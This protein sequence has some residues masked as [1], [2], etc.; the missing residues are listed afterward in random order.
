MT[1]QAA[2]R[3]TLAVL[4]KFYAHRDGSPHPLNE[5]QLVVYLDG[6]AAYPPE[7]LEAAARAWM[8]QSPFFPRLSDLLG[9]LA[10]CA[11]VEALAHL[12]WTRLE[13]EI[14]RIGAY[15]SV[16]FTDVAF[17]ETVRQVFG[18]WAEA[19]RYDADSPAWAIRRQTFLHIF[20]VLAARALEPTPVVLPG[21]HR[22]QVPACIGHLDGLPVT[23]PTLTSPDRTAFVLAEIERRRLARAEADDEQTVRRR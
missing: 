20:P 17:G 18:S 21:L 5:T 6:L 8:R 9:L 19:C 11:D 7:A 10:P 22:D 16:Q 14:R 13:A 3:S 2:V 12:A 23:P 4:Q 1:P 15:R